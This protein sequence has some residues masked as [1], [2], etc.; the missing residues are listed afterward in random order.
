MKAEESWGSEL[1]GPYNTQPVECYKVVGQN[2]TRMTCPSGPI[3]ER[4]FT[5]I[6]GDIQ[7]YLGVHKQSPGIPSDI[8]RIVSNA[9]QL[10]CDSVGDS[11]GL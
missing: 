9:F 8:P 2:I 4:E 1:R 5:G 7:G 10:G 3:A 11:R 6:H